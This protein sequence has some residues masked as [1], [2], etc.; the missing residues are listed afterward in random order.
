MCQDPTAEACVGCSETTFTMENAE[1]LVCEDNDR[2]IENVWV[3]CVNHAG[4][5]QEGDYSKEV[6]CDQISEPV[7]FNLYG[8][9]ISNR[10]C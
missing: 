3:S 8:S 10:D 1:R 4:N 9:D 5:L 6:R 2:A 7:I